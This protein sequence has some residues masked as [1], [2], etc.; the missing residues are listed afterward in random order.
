MENLI[1]KLEKK[2][3]FRKNEYIDEGRRANIYKINGVVVK[4][5]GKW[6]RNGYENEYLE[7]K[8]EDRYVKKLIKEFEDHKKYYDL[9]L[10]ES[11]VNIV[12]PHGVYAVR[13]T[14]SSIYYPGFIIDFLEGINL[15]GMKGSK[16]NYEF[17][18][19]FKGYSEKKF[20]EAKENFMHQKKIILN[21]GIYH[22]EISLGNAIWNPETDVVTLFDLDGWTEM[23]PEK[24]TEFE[25]NEDW[26]F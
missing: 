10:S 18:D 17:K 8:N 23:T 13:N 7:L 22:P 12:K 21:R 24:I 1:D 6:A 19:E 26:R 20:K 4:I 11:E 16:R 15:E 9:F 3:E 2:Y 25:G 14:D 5:P